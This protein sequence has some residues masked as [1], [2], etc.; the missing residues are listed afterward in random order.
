MKRMKITKNKIIRSLIIAGI[1][2]L[3]T[4]CKLPKNL[5]QRAENKNV[6]AAYINSQD[7]VNSAKVKWKDFFTDPNLNALI[8]TAL[9]NNQDM[10]ITMQEIR[11]ARNEIGAR[12][13]AYLP[14]LGVHAGAGVE[15]V[16]RF[17]SQGASD[18]ANDILPDQKVPE[19][20]PDFLLSAN[21]SWELDI[22]KKLRNSRKA[23]I[24][25]YL[26]SVEGKN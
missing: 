9:Q 8:E 13:G 1:P 24:K 7:S 3:F 23:A 22:W 16:G 20:L 14:F 10:N 2:L 4:Y 26:S 5:A 17:T 25:G 6:P 11:I 15:K 12:K 18:A 19:V 21:F